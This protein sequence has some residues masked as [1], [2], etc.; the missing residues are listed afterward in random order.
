MPLLMDK[1]KGSKQFRKGWRDVGD[2]RNNTEHKC[3][4]L[5]NVINF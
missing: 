4:F 3:Y 2:L 5:Y 1:I